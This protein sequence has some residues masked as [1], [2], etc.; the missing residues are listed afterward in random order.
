M[1]IDILIKHEDGRVAD[2][3][4]KD[5]S[6]W[7]IALAIKSV[8]KEGISVGMRSDCYGL[9][10]DVTGH[11]LPDK[12]CDD[13]NIWSNEDLRDM[14]RCLKYKAQNNCHGNV[15]SDDVGKIKKFLE[16]LIKNKLCIEI[17]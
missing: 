10:E 16:F 5:E 4:F 8:C 6:H 13:D 2:D 11:Y 7:H 9:I 1:G 14:A 3:I 12:Y 15:K 17:W